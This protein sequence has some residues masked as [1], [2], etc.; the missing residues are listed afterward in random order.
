MTRR[1]AFALCELA[2]VLLPRRRRV[3]GQAMKAELAYVAG[4]SAALAYAGGCIMAAAK[5]RMFDFETRFAAGL[6]SLALL[7]VACGIY[8][9]ACASRGLEVML[10]RP[11]GFLAALVRGGRASPELIATYHQAM[12]IVVACLFGLGFAH[13]VASY[14]LLRHEWERF[15]L[16]WCASLIVA[17][18]A[19]TVQLSVVW[20][21]NGL[22]SE[23]FALL[24]QAVALPMLLLWSNG[25]HRPLGRTE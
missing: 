12:P 1:A 20:S 16:A 18:A 14:F 23:L 15:L 24:V 22:P 3:W 6:G 5:A 19:V 25:R 11:D 10:G 2:T 9:I 7:G 17:I 4:G 8:H 13:L 21:G